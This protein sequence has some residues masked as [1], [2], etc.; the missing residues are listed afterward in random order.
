MSLLPLLIQTT[1]NFYRWRVRVQ[2]L[3]KEYKRR[4]QIIGKYLVYDSKM[5]YYK[6]RNNQVICCL[7]RGFHYNRK[8]CIYRFTEPTNRYKPVPKTAFPLPRKY[9]YSSGHNGVLGY[10]YC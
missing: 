8:K 1:L 7:E 2:T 6:Y 4:V 9:H 3:N 5:P 10:Y